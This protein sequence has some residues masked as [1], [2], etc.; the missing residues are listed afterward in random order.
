MTV[1]K[2]EQSLSATLEKT[3]QTLGG[4]E[5]SLD[6]N[7]EASLLATLENSE[8]NDGL[9]EGWCETT[10]GQ[11]TEYGKTKKVERKDVSDDLWLLELEDVEKGSS[12][13]VQR[14]S[15]SERAFKSTKNKF[16]KGSVLYGK[17]RPYL[18]KIVMAPEDGVC[19]T[20]IIPINVEPFGSNKYLFYWL[21]SGK[22]LGYVN[23]V[24]YG[25]NMPRL[26][27]KDGL[28][29][30]LVLPPLA[31]QTVIA[32]T[33]DTLLAQVD[34][35]KTR[36]DAIPKILKTFR[37]SVLAAAVN[38]KLTEEWRSENECEL[39]AWVSSSIGD[40]A[41]VATGTTPKRTNLDY[42]SGGSIPW[43]TS[44]STGKAFTSEAD[45]FVTELAVKEGR[46]KLFGPGTLLIAMYGEG[47]TRGQVT[48]LKMTATCNQACAAII[49]NEEIASKEF[50]KLR[51]IENY[52]ETRKVAVGGAQPNLNLSK[53]REILISLPSLKEQTEIVRR[54]EEL[55]AF[56]DQIEQQVK[57]AQKR[58]NTLTQS[59][60][61][62]AFRGE[63]TVQWRAENTALISG[64]NSAEALLAKIQEER[65]KLKPKKKSS[66]KKTTR[67]K[68][69]AMKA[70]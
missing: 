38:G 3:E 21:K 59:I 53:V 33:L 68:T 47:K 50:I 36:L 56:A 46:L 49:V 31:E 14:L 24:S 5:N 12:K 2:T 15:V 37:Q 63:L 6:N 29:A 22:F 43:L 61:A 20:E 13:I 52:E 51:L 4:L 39:S 23:K 57:N 27:T 10:L 34:N 64:E 40:V 35:I 17:L 18:N 9:P 41:T 11:F 54:V 25:V 70:S 30:P 7:E 19:T 26:G 16:E 48:E 58:V 32:Q 45:Q 8:A 55:F 42:W 60:L 1:K 67:K 65:E 44:A 62:K 28:S 69:T 66:V